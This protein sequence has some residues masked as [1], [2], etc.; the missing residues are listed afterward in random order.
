MADTMC[1]GGC[2]DP[3]SGPQSLDEGRRAWGLK[4]G[5]EGG[6]RMGMWSFWCLLAWF[7]ALTAATPGSINALEEIV[8]RASL[9]PAQCLPLDHRSLPPAC[10]ESPTA[11]T[12]LFLL[13]VGHPW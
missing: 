5:E 11:G 9:G 7:P 3:A 8:P 12:A 10:P 2:R 4:K 6:R 1:Q 13:R